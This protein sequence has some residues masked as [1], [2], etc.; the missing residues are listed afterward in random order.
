MLQN[1]RPK[2][3]MSSGLVTPGA[4]PASV[5]TSGISLDSM[6]PNAFQPS[7][8]DYLLMFPYLAIFR[9]IAFSKQL[10]RMIRGT[11]ASCQRLWQT[12]PNFRMNPQSV[13]IET[14]QSDSE[15]TQYST[16]V[17]N[18]STSG[19]RRRSGRSPVTFQKYTGLA[20]GLSGHNAELLTGIVQFEDEL[21]DPM[22]QPLLAAISNNLENEA[23][24]RRRLDHSHAV[25][26]TLSD[27]AMDGLSSMCKLLRMNSSAQVGIKSCS[28]YQQRWKLSS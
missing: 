3:Y 17:A 5:K 18:P 12:M 27:K 23:K 24:L 4:Y 25:Y 28:L 22:A 11:A 10:R 9:S 14:V 16:G 20:K 2:Y 19:L 21:S 26:L 1:E 13:N 6:A 15:Q 8:Y 7:G